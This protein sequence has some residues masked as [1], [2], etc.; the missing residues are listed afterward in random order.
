MYY[1]NH[2]NKDND[3]FVCQKEEVGRQLG[4]M[5]SE[6]HRKTELLQYQEHCIKELKDELGQIDVDEFLK[7]NTKVS[8]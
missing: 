3:D 4:R 6:M 2:G 1:T 5:K 7:G 8:K